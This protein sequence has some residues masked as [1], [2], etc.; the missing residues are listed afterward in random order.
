[1]FKYADFDIP[2]LKYSQL[3]QT[4]EFVT[5]LALD[6]GSLEFESVMLSIEK[7]QPL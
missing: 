1:M 2:G 7:N 3:Y 6:P 5:K 4:L